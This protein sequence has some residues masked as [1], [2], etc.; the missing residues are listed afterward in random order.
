MSTCANS[1]DHDWT[2][3]VMRNPFF[4]F[5]VFCAVITFITILINIY[6]YQCLK[7][8]ITKLKIANWAIEVL[9]ERIRLQEPNSILIEEITR[10]LNARDENMFGGFTIGDE[11]NGKKA[12]LKDKTALRE[13]IKGQKEA[14]E[15]KALIDARILVNT[16]MPNASSPP[17][18]ADSRIMKVT[19]A[20]IKE[21]KGILAL[22]KSKESIEEEPL[23]SQTQNKKQNNSIDLMSPRP[24]T[25]TNPNQSQNSSSKK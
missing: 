5:A 9:T 8:D 17:P 3:Y 20:M 21:T 23:I 13:M 4:W 19:R 2:I 22:G 25:P 11:N 15:T 12:E 1:D 10:K 7:K 18:N 24:P 16:P 6:N 14:D